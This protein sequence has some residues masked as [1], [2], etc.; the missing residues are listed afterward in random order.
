MC[1]IC[2]D[3]VVEAVDGIKVTAAHP[4]GPEV[5]SDGV[6]YHCRKW[7]YFAVFTTEPTIS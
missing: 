7:H 2:W 6:V 1:P 3:S 4:L 5:I